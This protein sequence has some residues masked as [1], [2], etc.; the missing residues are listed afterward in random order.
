METNQ[1]NAKIVTYS[2]KKI[3]AIAVVVLIIALAVA[4]ASGLLITSQNPSSIQTSNQNFPQFWIA[5]GAY[6]TY[7]GQTNVLSTLI[8]LNVKMEIVGVNETYIQVLTTFN[9]STPYG[10]TENT[11]TTWVNRE[12]MTFQ[13]DGM[14]LNSTYNTQV[15][16]P[17]LGTR[18]CTVYEY[19]SQSI[20]ATLYVDNSIQWPI[21]IIMTSPTVYGQS[22]SITLNLVDSNIP[23]L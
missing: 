16:L 17:K 20:S 6:A 12:N 9:M 18:S 15:T 13:P 22:Y 7:E 2:K 3:A 14:T 4:L 11:T 21:K 5:V 8:S 1:Q 23:G 19:T 10:T